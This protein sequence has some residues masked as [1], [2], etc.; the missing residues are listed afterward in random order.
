MPERN[1]L[2]NRTIQCIYQKNR[3]IKLLKKKV[4]NPSETDQKDRKMPK[5][6]TAET[7]PVTS[8]SKVIW[9]FWYGKWEVTRFDRGEHRGNLD[10]NNRKLDPVYYKGPLKNIANKWSSGMDLSIEKKYIT[11]WDQKGKEI[12][13]WD[14][15]SDSHGDQEVVIRLNPFTIRHDMHLYCDDKLF[16][17]RCV[18]MELHGWY[19]LGVRHKRYLNPDV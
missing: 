16:E 4:F 7:S 8:P 13:H 10:Y 11:M 6:T 15:H 3:N 18:R 2:V 5:T 1:Y 19:M 14:P 17:P 12:N 9:E